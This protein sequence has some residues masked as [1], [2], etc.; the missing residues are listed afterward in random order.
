[1]TSE[2][3]A[4]AQE[5]REEILTNVLSIYYLAAAANGW[6]EPPK[7]VAATM[8]EIFRLVTLGL[9]ITE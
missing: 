2:E 9:K 5:L 6:T 3:L 8:D 4:K 1:M 7:D